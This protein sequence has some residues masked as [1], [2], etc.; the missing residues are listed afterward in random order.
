MEQVQNGDKVKIHYMAKTNESILFDSSAQ[1]KSLEVTVGHEDI[2][3]TLEKALIGMKV[4]E[5]KSVPLPAQD[6][7]GPYV[8]EL[9]YSVEKTQLPQNITLSVGQQVKIQLDGEHPSLVTVK[10]I[11]HDAIVFDA[12]HPLAGKDL[13]FDLIVM[14]INK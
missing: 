10:E 11:S 8:P 14:E 2:L 5:K 4:G 7:F 9:I 12:N 13:V 6:A 1:K 3:P